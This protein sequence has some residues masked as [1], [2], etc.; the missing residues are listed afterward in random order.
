MT[1]V[2]LVAAIA[3]CCALLA[4]DSPT[5]PLLALKR[6]SPS[7]LE[8]TGMVAGVPPGTSRYVSYETLLTL[9]QVTVAVTGDDNFNEIPREKILVTG[10]Y[11][12]VLA[13]YLGAQPSSDLVS[14]L[15]SDGY[16]SI[17]SHDYVLS[18]RPIFALM[19]DGLPVK[20]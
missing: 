7:D 4:A 13:K 16:R 2:K 6:N 15:C 5:K 1:P 20:A 3:T 17:Y 9:P 18:H 14:A 12:D 11:L 10:I 8:I 19:I